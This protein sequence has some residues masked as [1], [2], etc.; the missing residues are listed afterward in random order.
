MSLVASDLDSAIIQEIKPHIAKDKTMC[1]NP[2]VM[3][4]ENWTDLIP[5][6]RV[7]MVSVVLFIVKAILVKFV[8]LFFSRVLSG[9]WPVPTAAS[10]RNSRIELTGLNKET[11]ENQSMESDQSDSPN[12]M[13]K[14]SDN[15]R[16]NRIKEKAS[17]KE[18][19]E[20]QTKTTRRGRKVQLPLR[21]RR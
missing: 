3:E 9:I 21:F 18:G 19:N 13:F 20:A 7:F 12:R 2:L 5:S 17:E 14:R 4:S 1:W 11:N 10:V 15:Q 6:F 16:K 8:F